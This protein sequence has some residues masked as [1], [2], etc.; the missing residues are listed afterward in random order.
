VELS[1]LHVLVGRKTEDA[2][3]VVAQTLRLVQGQE[4]E[5]GALVL[6]QLGL[7]LRGGNAGLLVQG[8]DASVVL[9]DEALQLGGTVR[10]LGRGL[11]ED[12][13]GG[14]L[15]HIVGHRLAALVLLVTGHK[16]S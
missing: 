9:P 8:L 10:E 1:L 3:R 6:L 7:K 2:V 5:E 13:V 14:R 16:A 15:V 4:L 11:A 12:L